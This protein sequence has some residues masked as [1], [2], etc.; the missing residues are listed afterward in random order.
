MGKLVKLESKSR[1]APR[2]RRRPQSRP[3]H[4]GM[5]EKS[6]LTPDLKAFIDAA[7]VPVLV[8]RYLALEGRENE[9]AKRDC[10]AGHSASTRP[11]RVRGK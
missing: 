9:L 6:P 1:M 3:A 11:H 5:R 2:I 4:A 7:I 10:D 8:K